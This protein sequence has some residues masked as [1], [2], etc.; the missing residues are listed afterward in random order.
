MSRLIT[1]ELRSQVI[2]MIADGVLL[3][4]ITLQLK[5]PYH[6]IKKIQADH[7]AAQRAE[8][9]A[10]SSGCVSGAVMHAV[11]G[12]SPRITAS[13]K[14][15]SR[16]MAVYQSLE[17]RYQGQRYENVERLPLADRLGVKPPLP[18]GYARHGCAATLC[19]DG[20]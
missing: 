11:T 15:S 2:G 13:I 16:L 5:L 17:R 18:E 4:D 7:R 9:D 3:S 8:L 19:V 12:L 14:A 10:M 20:G 1:Q 6:K